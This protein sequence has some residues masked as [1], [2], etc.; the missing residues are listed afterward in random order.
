MR[1]PPRQALS[2][3]ILA[4]GQGA[5]MGGRDTAR[6]RRGPNSLLEQLV[7]QLRPL[8]AEIIVARRRPRSALRLP[9]ACRLAWDR[10]AGAGPVAGLEAGLRRAR[11]A[12]C[13]CLPVDGLNPPAD[14]P[15]QLSRGHG[16][17]A[18]AL[19]GGDAYYLHSLIP[20]DKRRALSGFLAGGGRSATNACRQ[21]KLTPRPI[22]RARATVWSINTREEW[23]AT[24]RRAP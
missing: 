23:R 20:R 19:H 9:T 1:P 7:R 18:Y 16:R 14:L 15:R 11:R 5:R 2:A 21:L 8:T 12:W 3:V 6:L 4:G 24:C 10:R 17:G 22:G 13:L